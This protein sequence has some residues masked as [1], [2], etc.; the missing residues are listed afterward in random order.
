MSIL[1]VDVCVC[2][3]VRRGKKELINVQLLGC[4]DYSSPLTLV[5]SFSGYGVGT[6][7]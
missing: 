2:V 6:P 3:C 4:S 7:S 1:S 5:F